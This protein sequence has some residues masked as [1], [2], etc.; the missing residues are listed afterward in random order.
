MITAGPAFGAPTAADKCESAKNV[1]AGK[2]A[3]CREK[4]EG[5]FVVTGDA[6]KYTDA[7]T[8]CAA[9]FSAK[10]ADLETDASGACPTNG[11]ATDIETAVRTLTDSI[12]LSLSGASGGSGFTDNG[13]GTIIDNERGLQWEKKAGFDYS[14]NFADLHEADNYHLWANLCSLNA[15]KE[16][17]PST[18]AALACDAGAVGSSLSCAECGPGEGTCTTYTG[19]TVWEWL[20]SLN[21]SNFAGHNDWR[22]PTIAELTSL[23][24]YTDAVIPTVEGAFQGASCG[25]SCVDLT[26]PNCSCTHPN[27]YWAASVY[28]STPYMSW[29]VNF[30][31]GNVL[32][33]SQTTNGRVRAVRDL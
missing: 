15:A 2:Y 5:K 32:A 28:V 7:L 17:Q 25:A 30:F 23:T 27:A 10:W 12:A 3:A 22:L 20:V 24:D 26:D 6:L 33:T 19:T 1:T 4:A 13:D 21:N 16:C 8:K 11:D 31:D 14:E 9:K 29:Y 18:A